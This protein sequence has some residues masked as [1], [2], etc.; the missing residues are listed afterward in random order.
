MA[1]ATIASRATGFVRVLM[2]A[3]ALG[4]GSRLLDSYNMANTL[5]NTVYELIAGGA[6]ASVIVPLLTRAA[7]TER[8]GGVVYAQ[9]LMSLLAYGL[10]VVT[11]LA[12]LL[13]PYLV[14]LCAPGF[15]SD[16]RHL[17]VVFSRFFLP[18]ILFYG[19]GAAGGT[20]GQQSRGHSGR[21]DLPGR[22]RRDRPPRVDPGP[23]AAARGRH[24]R[25]CDRKDDG[26]VVGARPQ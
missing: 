6:M 21:V 10:G 26:C 2:L 15:T 12:T 13:A 9:R 25:R 19:L 20:S 22:R 7:L 4:F 3:A 1:V 17:A 11:V 23:G 18:Q 24:H 5:P 16:Q 8:D 14:D